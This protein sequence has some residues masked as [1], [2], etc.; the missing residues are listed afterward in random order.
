MEHGVDRGGDLLRAG[1]LQQDAARAGGHDLR[2]QL[3]CR[4]GRP[5]EDPAV[6]GDGSEPANEIGT[7]EAFDLELGDD[8]VR[9]DPLRHLDRVIAVEDHLHLEVGVGSDERVLEERDRL[10][11]VAQEDRCGHVMEI[12]TGPMEGLSGPRVAAVC[13]STIPPRIAIATACARSFAPSFSKIR[14]RW[15]FTV[16]GEIPRSC[17]TSRVVAP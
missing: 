9:V 2:D 17:A 14:S 4:D 3:G 11:A 8:Q 7:R 12:S 13:Y 10:G 1:F 16:C 15:V 6:G 5:T